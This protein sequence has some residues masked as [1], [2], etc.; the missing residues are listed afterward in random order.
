MIHW[1]L[2]IICAICATTAAGQD[3]RFP[4]N[5]TVTRE[6]T[7]ASDSYAMP[8]GPWVD[9]ALPI[10]T[11]DGQLKQQA[12]TIT[13]TGLTTL[14]LIQPLRAQLL[15]AGFEIIYECRDQNCGGF[16][17]RFQTEV[18]PPPE[19]QVDLGN[20]RYFAARKDDGAELISVIASRSARSGFVQVTR[21]GPSDV[22][23]NAP[24]FH[25]T[26]PMA[27]PSDLSK[28][29]VQNGHVVLNGLYFETGSSKLGRGRY[30]T[31]QALADF[32]TTNPDLKIALV[33]HTDSSGSLDSNITLSIQRA[34]SV[35]EKLV[36]NYNVNR[37]QLKA[38]G[39]GYLD[40][41]ASNQT[42]IGRAKNRRVEVIITITN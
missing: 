13:A 39:M 34:K 23:A 28:S 18:L 10:E 25:E 22:T 4:S 12:W 7:R 33:G 40:P 31:L 36:S 41:I 1:A 20:F 5:A 16:D 6:I 14:Q 37:A 17:F 11:A 38:Q 19:M 15:N 32:L 30:D 2:A 3:L 35:L 21:I 27:Q 26:T 24:P 9:G 29:L 8:V 42:Q